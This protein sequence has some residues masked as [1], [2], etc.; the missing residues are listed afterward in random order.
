MTQFIPLQ[1]YRKFDSQF[2]QSLAREGHFFLV[3]QSYKRA[4]EETDHTNIPLLFS[5]YKDVKEASQHCN[6]LVRMKDK[7]AAFVDI[8]ETKITAK[9]VNICNGNTNKIAY[10]ARVGN[11]DYVNRY[12]DR[13]YYEKMRSWVRKNRE[14][15]IREPNSL[16]PFFLTVM[17]EP[18][19]NIK[20]GSHSVMVKV[21]DLERM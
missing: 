20:W 4:N 16:Q 3:S 18:M 8:R 6:Y 14:W 15:K 19:V 13:H 1:P 2:I 11:L 7:Y 5:D 21:E 12:I 10:I 9:I 17:G